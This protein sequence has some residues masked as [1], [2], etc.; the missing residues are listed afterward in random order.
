VR[1][2][3]SRRNS[4]PGV[5]PGPAAAARLKSPNVQIPNDLDR[6]QYTGW[7]DHKSRSWKLHTLAAKTAANQQTA[8]TT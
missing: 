4:W 7:D 3:R 1:P 5:P 6:P 2:D 8:Q